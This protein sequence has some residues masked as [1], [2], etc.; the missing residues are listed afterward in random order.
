MMPKRLQQHISS[1]TTKWKNQ[2]LIT[3]KTSDGMSKQQAEEVI[4]ALKQ[5]RASGSLPPME[6]EYNPHPRIFGSDPLYL[7]PKTEDP[8]QL[9]DLHSR[10][11]T[12]LHTAFGDK[13]VIA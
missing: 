12:I 3:P 11:R 13:Y 2:L 1:I 9:K 4:E 7:Y 10:V 6:Y 5:A 8:T